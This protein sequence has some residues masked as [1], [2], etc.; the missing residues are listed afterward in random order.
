M[1]KK[2]DLEAIV[3][4]LYEWCLEHEDGYAAIEI[5][6][7]SDGTVVCSGNGDTNKPGWYVDTRIY[8]KMDPSAAAT[9]K[10]PNN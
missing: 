9:A 8:K 5:I 3:D 4:L 2:E 6:T 10:S 1:K 7:R